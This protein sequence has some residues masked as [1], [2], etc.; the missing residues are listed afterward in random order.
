MTDRQ[1]L[2]EVS[3]NPENRRAGAR[4]FRQSMANFRRGAEVEALC[5]PMR[6]G[7]AGA[8]KLAA[9]EQLLSFPR[10]EPRPEDPAAAAA[11]RC[12]L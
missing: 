6:N 3:R 2:V 12:A 9:D 1:D 11:H 8:V 10:R 5:R 7:A 4:Y